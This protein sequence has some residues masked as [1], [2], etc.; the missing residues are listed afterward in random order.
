MSEDFGTGMIVGIVIGVIIV[1]IIVFGASIATESIEVPTLDKA[2]RLIMNDS[3]A[4]FYQE[5][6]IQNDFPC[7]LNDRV[8]FDL[9]EHIS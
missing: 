9:L 4:T 7:E 8:Y 2:C 6:G 5:S 3:M 1:G